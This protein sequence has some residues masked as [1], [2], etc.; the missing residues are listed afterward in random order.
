MYKRQHR[1]DQ[2]Q[3]DTTRYSVPG[4]ASRQGRLNSG[5]HSKA[6]RI[7]ARPLSATTDQ[8]LR[9][10]GRSITKRKDTDPDLRCGTQPRTGRIPTRTLANQADQ[11]FRKPKPAPR[12]GQAQGWTANNP[13]KER[14]RI[15]I[16]NRTYEVKQNI[17]TYTQIYNLSQNTPYTPRPSFFPRLLRRQVKPGTWDRPSQAT[18][19]TYRP[20]LNPALIRHQKQLSLIHI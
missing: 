14:S 10:V 15:T 20:H 18:P 5:T 16:E 7:A 1:S 19:Y 8:A 2:A 17:Y 12:G 11:A 3:A 6:R 9:K 13:D 4:S